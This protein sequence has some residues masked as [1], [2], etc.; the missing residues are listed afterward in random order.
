MKRHRTHKRWSQEEIIAVKN[1][2]YVG[3]SETK[4]G[5]FARSLDRTKQAVYCK[6]QGLMRKEKSSSINLIKRSHKVTDTQYKGFMDK[7]LD[8]ATSA[9]LVDDK[10]HIYF[11]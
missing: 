3:L 5:I 10:I 9:T 4:R 8:R 7:L 11:K 1:S 6:Y 2:N